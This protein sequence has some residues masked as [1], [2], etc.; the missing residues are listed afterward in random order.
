[1]TC[2][3]LLDG[4]H[5]EKS[6]DG[7]RCVFCGALQDP[8]TDEAPRAPTP[9][10]VGDIL[11]RAREARK[12]S[13]EHAASETRI[14]ERFLRV[15]EDDEPFDAYPGAV[16]G[17]FFLREYAEHLGVDA[18]P[19][20]EAY[21]RVGREEDFALVIDRALPKDPS[22]GKRLITAI[23]TIALLVIAGL[24]WWTGGRPEEVPAARI[25]VVS[26]PSSPVHLR[27]T[28]PVE[29]EQPR[30]TPPGVRAIVRI[31]APCW[32]QAVVDDRT[33][34]GETLLAG[35]QRSFR[36]DRALELTL[37]NPGGARVWVNGR[38]VQTGPSDQVAHLSYA[39]RHGRLVGGRA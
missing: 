35:T 39:W 6:I 38:L 13:L 19:L 10:G 24:S 34:K 30:V 16:Y 31:V 12:E 28:R 23:A 17:R 27:A 1:M 2:G 20:L 5:L 11:R 4:E 32:V 9:I 37:G 26:T 36:A 22:R 18:G 33:F 15:L 14:H 7:E 3:A 29:G 21:D 8:A 25:P